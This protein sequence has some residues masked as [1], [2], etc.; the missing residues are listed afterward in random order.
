MEIVYRFS[1]P[2]SGFKF[3]PA[4]YFPPP[5][6]FQRRSRTA[7]G[8]LPARDNNLHPRRSTASRINVELKQASRT[9]HSCTAFSPFVHSSR[10]SFSLPPSVSLHRAFEYGRRCWKKV[11]A[12]LRDNLS[13]LGRVFESSFR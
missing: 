6:F 4:S 3:V 13:R 8:R 7:V 1:N 11:L 10:L 5:S 9:F 12:A 2:V